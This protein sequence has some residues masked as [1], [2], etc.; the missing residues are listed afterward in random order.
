M[1][2]GKHEWQFEM[3]VRNISMTDDR[4]LACFVTILSL[5][6]FLP[7]LVERFAEDVLGHVQHS[8]MYSVSR[9]SRRLCFLCRHCFAPFTTSSSQRPQASPLSSL[10][11]S[12]L[13]ATPV[14]VRKS[15]LG[16]QVSASFDLFH[17]ILKF[18]WGKITHEDTERA[19]QK[20]GDG[21]TYR[22]S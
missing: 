7:K 6:R 14:V 5:R 4:M 2:H 19:Q 11:C 17:K 8:P 9:R 3:F 20:I 13:A 21:G 1:E 18:L 15:R 22:D 10:R 12:R 16:F